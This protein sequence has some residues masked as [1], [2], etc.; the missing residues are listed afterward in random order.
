MSLV[1]DDDEDDAGGPGKSFFKGKEERRGKMV[2]KSCEEKG[3]GGKVRKSGGSKGA[4]FKKPVRRNSFPSKGS[5]GAVFVL[6]AACHD[7]IL[8]RMSRQLY[9]VGFGRR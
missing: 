5:W 2:E 9:D 3:G 1:G 6:C 4:S 7:G 8:R